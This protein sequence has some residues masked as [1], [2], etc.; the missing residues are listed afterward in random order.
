MSNGLN[1]V[2]N[3]RDHEIYFILLA[4]F[5]HKSFEMNKLS[6]TIFKDM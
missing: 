4:Y 2:K 1:R 3:C 6:Y 5:F